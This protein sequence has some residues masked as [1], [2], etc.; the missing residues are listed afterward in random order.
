LLESAYEARLCRELVA[1]GE[2]QRAMSLIYK[3]IQLDCGYRM[4]LVVGD[5]VLVE[6]KTVGALLPSTSPRS[7]RT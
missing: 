7:S 5:R 2:R 1:R 4:D 6:L 3:G